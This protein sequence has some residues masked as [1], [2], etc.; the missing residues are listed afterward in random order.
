MVYV[1]QRAF[2]EALVAPGVYSRPPSRS[3]PPRLSTIEYSRSLV[4]CKCTREHSFALFR[5]FMLQV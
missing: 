4:D 3:A 1:S 5:E 2:C